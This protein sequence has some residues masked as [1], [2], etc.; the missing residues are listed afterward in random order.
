MKND[1]IFDQRCLFNAQ[2]EMILVDII[3]WYCLAFIPLSTIEFIDYVQSNILNNQQ[4]DGNRWFSN[5]IDRYKNE[6][7]IKSIST[8]GYDHIMKIFFYNFKEFIY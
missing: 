1:E 8:I 6:I 2:T 3:K 5:F 4:L 7:D